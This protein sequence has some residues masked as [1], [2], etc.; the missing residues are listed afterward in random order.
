MR[1]MV[2]CPACLHEFDL[3]QARNDNDWR[4]LVQVILR[5]PEC[6]HRPV[7]QY[8][9]LF[10]GKQQIRSL[11]MY[12]IVK[13]LEPMIKSAK[14]QRNRLE[15]VVTAQ[16]FAQAMSYLVDTRLESLVLPLKSN[17]Y[18]LGMLANQ[19]EQTLAKV[20][21]KRETDLR[22]R[23]PVSV[24]VDAPA[25]N[26]SKPKPS[27]VDEIFKKT[28]LAQTNNLLET[29]TKPVINED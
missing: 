19:A 21:Q 28:L 25:V 17:G 24:P 27:K 11:K 22:N 16:Q 1:V 6:V 3:E 29:Q 5:L 15:Y 12:R 26:A 10:Q 20:E 8:L 7:W 18:L 23:Q 4:D 13:E 14:L 9:G 2:N